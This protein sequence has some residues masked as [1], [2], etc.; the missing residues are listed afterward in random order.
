MS[1]LTSATTQ[2]VHLYIILNIEFVQSH[3]QWH[4]IMTEVLYPVIYIFLVWSKISWSTELKAVPEPR[5][6]LSLTDL[7]QPS[8]VIIG[9]QPKNGTDS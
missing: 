7:R 9:Y 4:S 2:C 6:V 3:F 1:M 8:T 5:D